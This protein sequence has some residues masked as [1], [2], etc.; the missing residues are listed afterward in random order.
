MSNFDY[1]IDEGMESKLREGGTFR[2]HAAYNFNGVVWFA[3]GLFYEEVWV[4]RSPR[5]TFTSDSLR[6]LMEEVNS[7]FGS[8]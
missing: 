5:A 6:C 8:A 4:Y 2:R 3:D 1:Q 7:E